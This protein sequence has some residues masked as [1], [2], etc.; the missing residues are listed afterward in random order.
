M[1]HTLFREGR[2][3]TVYKPCDAHYTHAHV[4]EIKRKIGLIIADNDG[5]DLVL[6]CQ[7]LTMLDGD[8]IGLIAWA[9]QKLMLDNR[10]FMLDNVFG[11][12]EEMLKTLGIYNL[13][14]NGAHND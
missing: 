12:P 5:C 2:D 3:I 1:T 9:Q 6:D 11:Q 14:T 7:D 8:G 4:K 13:L 10:K